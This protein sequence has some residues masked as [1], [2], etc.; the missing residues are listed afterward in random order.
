MNLRFLGYFSGIFDRWDE[1]LPG[2]FY[3]KPLW[4]LFRYFEIYG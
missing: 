3:Q 1:N 4:F 2:I